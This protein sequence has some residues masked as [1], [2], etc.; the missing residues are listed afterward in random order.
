MNRFIDLCV[1]F[2]ETMSNVGQV[3]AFR[4]IR[5]YG[6]IEEIIAKVYVQRCNYVQS[7]KQLGIRR[8][9]KIILK[10]NGR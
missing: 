2:C 7:A 3:R 6:K 8:S 5:K 10:S 1:L 9:A 4:F